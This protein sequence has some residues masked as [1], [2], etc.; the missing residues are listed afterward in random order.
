MSKG[1]YDDI[2]NLPRPEPIRSRMPI[3]NRAAQF[4]PF[5]AL[6]GYDETI[7]ETARLTDD[8][9]ELDEYIKARLDKKLDILKEQ[10]GNEPEITVT[11]F[12]RDETK[13]GGAYVSV[14]G[15]ARKIDYNSRI[16]IMRDGT[17]IPINDIINITGDIVKFIE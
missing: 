7:E 4:M 2:I 8:R 13:P 10:I 17:R 6:T 5:A 1:P 3:Q 12:K 16:I 14:H 15:T 11:Y 9:I